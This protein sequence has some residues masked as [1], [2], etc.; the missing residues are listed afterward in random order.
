M[1]NTITSIAL[2]PGV[3][4]NGR[5]YTRENI[6]S[7]YARL[8][9]RI[10]DPDGAPVNMR[11]HHGAGDDSTRIAAQVHKVSL[12]KDG[13]IAYEALP[14]DTAAANDIAGLTKPHPKT[15]K[16]S[17]AVSISGWWLG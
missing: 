13:A 17:V 1:A 4:K 14:V 12:T 5:L 6:A 10:K 3:S 8:A 9:K 7:A 11:T 16:P 15:G 2:A